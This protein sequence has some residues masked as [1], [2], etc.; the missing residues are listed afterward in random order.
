M[1]TEAKLKKLRAI[2]KAMD[3]VLIAFSGGVDS[4][5][6]LS[7][8]NGVL[9]DRLLA[10]TGV[11]K[12]IPGSEIEQAVSLARKL[13]VR[14]RLIADIPPKEFWEN[15]ARRC[16][17]C[18]KALFSRLKKI[19][20]KEKLKFVLDATNRDDLRDYRPGSRALRELGIRSP[21]KEAGLTKSEIRQ[22]SRKIG[23]ATWKKPAMACLA[24][25]VPYGERITP[26]KLLMIGQA[27]E[28]LRKLGFS[29]VRVRLQGRS[30]RVEVA[31]DK[32]PAAIRSRGKIFR[33]LKA[34]GFVYV[35][36]DLEGYRCGSA[37]EVLG[38]KRKK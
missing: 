34:L 38:W 23:L 16:Y 33:K 20:E 15:P 14:H 24:S 32:I 8:A 31:R 35:S 21:L 12:S 36:L 37:N 4:S 1:G 3:S 10:V 29:L 13:K 22:L 6:L 11:S 7:A 19:A 27:E 18:K 25:R 2:L 30:G 5:F 26:E 28:Y 17:Y 9:K